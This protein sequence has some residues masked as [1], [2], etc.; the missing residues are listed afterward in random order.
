[1]RW[2]KQFCFLRSWGVFPLKIPPSKTLD[3]MIRH[4]IEA[5]RRAGYVEAGLIKVEQIG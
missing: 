5:A 4:S 1:M 3:E 2:L